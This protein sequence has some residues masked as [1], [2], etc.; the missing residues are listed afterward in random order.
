MSSWASLG[1]ARELAGLV[2]SDIFMLFR[3]LSRGGSNFG[4]RDRT[5]GTCNAG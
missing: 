3:E 5:G 4:G 1:Q 2:V